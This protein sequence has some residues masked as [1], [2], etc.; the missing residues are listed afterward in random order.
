MYFDHAVKLMG[1]VED[2]RLADS[3]VACIEAK[4]PDPG[5]PKQVPGMP[6]AFIHPV[7]ARYV[8]EAGDYIPTRDAKALI[9]ARQGGQRRRLLDWSVHAG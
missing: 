9:M 5:N 1:S 4:R 3:L 6:P 2:K 7:N 8:S